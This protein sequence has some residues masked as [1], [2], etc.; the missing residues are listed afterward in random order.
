MW[1]RR[2]RIV[3]EVGQSNYCL[4]QIVPSSQAH[5]THTVFNPPTQRILSWSM[6]LLYQY[7]CIPKIGLEFKYEFSTVLFYTNLLQHICLNGGKDF[8]QTL[9]THWKMWNFKLKVWKSEEKEFTWWG[10]PK[11]TRQMFLIQSSFPTD[12]NLPK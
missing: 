1:R 3:W 12:N 9:L 5:T 7:K 11:R 4:C 6:K 8:F 10:T 2:S